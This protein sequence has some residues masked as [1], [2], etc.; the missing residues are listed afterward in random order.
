MKTVYV[1]EVRHHNEYYH[2]GSCITVFRDR[3]KA[4]DEMYE[5]LRITYYDSMDEDTK[6]YFDECAADRSNCF[7]ARGLFDA[8]VWE[9]MLF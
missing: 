8:E 7:E 2:E 5:Y 9:T 6:E 3:D 4:L 1:L